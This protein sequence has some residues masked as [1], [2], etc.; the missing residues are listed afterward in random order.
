VESETSLRT[1]TNSWS[2]TGA[3]SFDGPQVSLHQLA[4]SD[5][6]AAATELH[7]RRRTSQALRDIMIVTLARCCPTMA[8]ESIL[9][10]VSRQTERGVEQ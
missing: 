4:H 2:D 8:P 10:A 9:A 6:I 7:A 5:V 3:S 1:S